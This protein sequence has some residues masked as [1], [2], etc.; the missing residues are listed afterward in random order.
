ML[1]AMGER[2]RDPKL[3][4]YY[5]DNKPSTPGS[6]SSKRTWRLPCK[7]ADFALDKE[8][9]QIGGAKVSLLNELKAVYQVKAQ[10]QAK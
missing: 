8:T 1:A 7:L 3:I 6:R 5:K 4:D 9:F 10:A 2:G